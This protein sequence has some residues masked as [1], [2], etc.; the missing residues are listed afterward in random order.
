M[1][2]YFKLSKYTINY[3]KRKLLKNMI[4]FN[5]YKACVFKNQ[6]IK[7]KNSIFNHNV[8]SIFS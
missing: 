8:F 5:F 3:G 7:K 1:L 2:L 6:V 4:N